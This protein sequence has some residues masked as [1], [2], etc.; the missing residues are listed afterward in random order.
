MPGLRKNFCE[1]LGLWSLAHI[2]GVLY[3]NLTAELGCSFWAGGGD[4]V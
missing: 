4:E 3:K 1:V 2:K